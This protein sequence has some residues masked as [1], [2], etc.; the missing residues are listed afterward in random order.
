MNSKKFIVINE[1][2]P[3]SEVININNIALIERIDGKVK[4]TLNVKDQD[5]RQVIF[6]INE[7]YETFKKKIL[8][9]DNE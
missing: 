7:M 2:H 6:V 5:D 8:E 3:D 1:F 9:M 4:I